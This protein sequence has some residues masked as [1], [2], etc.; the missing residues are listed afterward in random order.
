[1]LGVEAGLAALFHFLSKVTHGLLRD[2]ATFATCYRGFG[3]VE[4]CQKLRSLAF[5][6]FPL[7]E[8]FLHRILGTAKPASLY[9]LAD[10]GFLIGSQSHF[11]DLS[12]R[13]GNARVK[14]ISLQVAVSALNI[15]T[16]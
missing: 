4:S 14:H 11:H 16:Y 8:R 9:R 15:C 13:G 5:A 6:F 12:V 1:V 10:K 7:R 2:N 3:I